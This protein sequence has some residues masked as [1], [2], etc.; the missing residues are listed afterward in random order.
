MYKTQTL[1]MFESLISVRIC[2]RFNK[3]EKR[4]CVA[5]TGDMKIFFLFCI[6]M[7]E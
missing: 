2:D 6:I 7:K 4:K 3:E 1:A 5:G